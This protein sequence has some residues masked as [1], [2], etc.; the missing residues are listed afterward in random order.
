MPLPT[1]IS[2]SYLINVNG[3]P[4]VISRR[5]LL[6]SCGVDVAESRLQSR[7]DRCLLRVGVLECAE[8]DGRDLCAGVQGVDFLVA[9]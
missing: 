9:R 3:G 7:A 4:E 1:W 8:A 6:H 5:S 2:V